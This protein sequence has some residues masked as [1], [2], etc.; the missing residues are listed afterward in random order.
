MTSTNCLW[1]QLPTPRK[2]SKKSKLSKNKK[3][4]LLLKHSSIRPKIMNM[5]LMTPFSFQMVRFSY[6]KTLTKNLAIYVNVSSICHWIG[7][8]V[9]IVVTLF[10]SNVGSSKRISRMPIISTCQRSRLGV[11]RALKELAKYAKFAIENSFSSNK[12]KEFKQRQRQKIT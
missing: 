1:V 6:R 8:P 11:G 12:C 9:T 5:L 2:W 10:A 4:H 3:T 7:G